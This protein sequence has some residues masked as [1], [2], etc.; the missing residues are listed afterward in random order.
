[1]G[2]DK[3]IIP[4]SYY[5]LSSIIISF[6]ILLFTISLF[7]FLNELEIYQRILIP[8]AGI[9][10]ILIIFIFT[11]NRLE[12]IKNDSDNKVIIKTINLLCFAKKKIILYRENTHFYTKLESDRDDNF[13]IKL[14]IINDYHNLIDI[15]LDTSNIKHKPAK[16]Y[17][18]FDHIGPTRN[19]SYNT[20]E[21]ELNKF[22][23]SD[24]NNKNPLISQ[25]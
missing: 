5:P 19:Y 18:F 4:F 25:I 9:I 15:D 22:I 3:F 16:F 10:I 12:I 7:F 2:D 17:Y 6:S 20:F 21:E 23:G 11:N 8:I 24:E 1:M 13:S 14:I